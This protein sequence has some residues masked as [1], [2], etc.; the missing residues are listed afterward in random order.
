[1]IIDVKKDHLDAYTSIKNPGSV[2]QKIQANAVIRDIFGRSFEMSSA[3]MLIA[4][5]EEKT[6]HFYVAKEKWWYFNYFGNKKAISWYR[7]PYL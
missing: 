4:P 2:A 7:G 5:N 6:I 3:E 1:L